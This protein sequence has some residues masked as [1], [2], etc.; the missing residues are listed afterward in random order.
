M[1]ILLYNLTI[2]V[3][4]YRYILLHASKSDMKNAARTVSCAL[5]SSSNNLTISRPHCTSKRPSL[6]RAESGADVHV[7]GVP[8]PYAD[9]RFLPRSWGMTLDDERHGTS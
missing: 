1:C 5:Y 2:E 7:C 4:D 9:L 3:H 8:V 6:Y